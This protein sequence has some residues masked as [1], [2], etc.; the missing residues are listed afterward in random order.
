MSADLSQACEAVAAV[1]RASMWAI[2]SSVLVESPSTSIMPIPTTD[3]TASAM[4]VRRS[5]RSSFVISRFVAGVLGVLASSPSGPELTRSVG[6]AEGIVPYVLTMSKRC[7]TVCGSGGSSLGRRQTV[8]IGAVER[9]RGRW[10]R[11]LSNTK[12]YRPELCWGA[13]GAQ[14]EPCDWSIKCTCT[15]TSKRAKGSE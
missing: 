7:S 2:F 13:G 8:Q 15:T 11:G 4:P 6:P 10:P 12:V 14:F 9:S 3:E 1:V 5:E